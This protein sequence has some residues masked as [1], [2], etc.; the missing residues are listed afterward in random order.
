MGAQK[1]PAGGGAGTGGSLTSA[2]GWK[3]IFMCLGWEGLQQ[4]LVEFFT[5]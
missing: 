3:H 1:T 4:D 5:L 2:V